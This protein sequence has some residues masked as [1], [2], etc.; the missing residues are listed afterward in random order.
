[1]VQVGWR[2]LRIL[3]SSHTFVCLL[4]GMC[5]VYLHMKRISSNLKSQNGVGVL[6]HNL[7]FTISCVCAQV[8]DGLTKIRF[9]EPDLNL[10]FLREH[11]PTDED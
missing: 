4:Y 5:A 2:V 6:F 9:I 7:V 11:I 8:G 1:M 3:Y 10:I